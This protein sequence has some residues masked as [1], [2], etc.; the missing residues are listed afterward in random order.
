MLSMLTY[1]WFRPL[2]WKGYKKPLESKDLWDI[3]EKDKSRSIVPIYDKYWEYSLKKAAKYC[4][5]FII[6]CNKQR[7]CNIL[8]II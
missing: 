2:A 5:K 8:F 3:N 1:Y 6:I 7:N 4:L